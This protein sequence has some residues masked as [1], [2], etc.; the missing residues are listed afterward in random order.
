MAARKAASVLPEPVGAATSAPSPSRIARQ[1]S[2]WQGVGA[3]KRRRN[4]RLTAGC[5]VSSAQTGVSFK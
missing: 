5:S 3:P 1:A 4:Q 2:S